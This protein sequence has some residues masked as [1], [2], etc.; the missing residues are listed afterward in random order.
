[1]KVAPDKRRRWIRTPVRD[2]R[3]VILVPIFS[4]EFTIGSWLL[5]K[6]VRIP[7]RT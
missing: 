4:F 7:E 2:R 6:G 1:M 3:A 5:I